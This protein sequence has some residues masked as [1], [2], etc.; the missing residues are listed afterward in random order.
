MIPRFCSFLIGN[1]TI[2]LIFSSVV[3]TC[4][5]SLGLLAGQVVLGISLLLL[6]NL[7]SGFPIQSLASPWNPQIA[8]VQL[9][10]VT[11]F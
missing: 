3:R 4:V 11:V 8:T 2:P 9:K 10:I 5:P 6:D 7:D 1:L